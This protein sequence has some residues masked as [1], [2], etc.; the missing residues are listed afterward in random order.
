MNEAELLFSEV[1]GCDRASLCLNRD[2]NLREDQAAF[3]SS[4]LKRRISGEQIQYILGKTEFMGLELKVNQ[5]VLIPRPETEILVE[6]TLKY[7]DKGKRIKIL[8]LGT[9]SG[10]H[11]D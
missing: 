4:A 5:N 11:A 2:K 1:L 10:W 3:I 9:G 8:D 7:A 6:T